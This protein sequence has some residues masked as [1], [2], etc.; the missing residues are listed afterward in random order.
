MTEETRS[1]SDSR[2][3]MSEIDRWLHNPEIHLD[4]KSRR[5]MLEKVIDKHIEKVR[6][7]ERFRVRAKDFLLLAAVA[8]VFASFFPNIIKL[9]EAATQ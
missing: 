2:N 6:S 3:L 7:A 1:Q 9:F 4:Q 8:T 5:D